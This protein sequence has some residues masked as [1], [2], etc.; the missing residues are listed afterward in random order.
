MEGRAPDYYRRNTVFD[1]KL[2]KKRDVE[3]APLEDGLIPPGGHVPPDEQG[4][5]SPMHCMFTVSHPTHL[6]NCP[7]GNQEKRRQSTR[8]NL[9]DNS[10]REK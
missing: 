3:E 4:W 8:Q 1:L 6:W 5:E 2:L 7:A 10:R 9:T